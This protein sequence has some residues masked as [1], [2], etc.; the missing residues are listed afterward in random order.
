MLREFVGGRVRTGPTEE[1]GGGGAA[2][3]SE[4]ACRNAT[5]GEKRKE[6]ERREKEKNEGTQVTPELTESGCS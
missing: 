3:P 1:W 4:R 5:N 6:G 2:A